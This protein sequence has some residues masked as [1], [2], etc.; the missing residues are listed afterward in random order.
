MST[1]EGEV[2]IS[3]G[4]GNIAV[5][6]D[7]TTVNVETAFNGRTRNHDASDDVLNLVMMTHMRCPPSRLHRTISPELNSLVIGEMMPF[8]RELGCLS[9]V[10][11]VPD[12]TSSMPS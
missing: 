11:A 7:G 3:L 8:L 10:D 1:S 9:N 5:V 12:V 4:S 6:S 2:R